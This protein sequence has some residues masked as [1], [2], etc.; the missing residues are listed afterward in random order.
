MHYKGTL[1]IVRATRA[2]ERRLLEYMLVESDEEGYPF[3]LV[4]ISGYYAGEV[5]GFVAEDPVAI[6]QLKDAVTRSHLEQELK[7]NLGDDV[8]VVAIH[9]PPDSVFGFS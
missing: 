8:E 6:H 1:V 3:Q 5:I 7:R 2:S 4:C 9:R